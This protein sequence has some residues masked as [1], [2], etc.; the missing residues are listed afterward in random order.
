MNA[1]TDGRSGF[2]LAAAVR[3]FCGGVDGGVGGSLPSLETV[4]F[5]Q[6]I[7]SEAFSARYEIISIDTGKQTK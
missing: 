3:E 2:A 6:Q 4:L 5:S 1:S 7:T